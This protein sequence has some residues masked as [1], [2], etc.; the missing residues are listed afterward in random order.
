MKT[1]IKLLGPVILLG[2]LGAPMIGCED[3]DLTAPADGTIV[4]TANPAT[5]T[6]DPNAADP[7]RDPETG[8]LMAQSTI[9]ARV[10]D[11][12]GLPQ[13]NV[14]VIFST[15]AGRLDSAGAPGAPVQSIK[16]NANGVAQDVLTVRENDPADIT[17]TAQSSSIS[18]DVAVT[19][20]VSGLN[21]PPRASINPV[22]FAGGLAGEPVVFDGS[23]SVDPDGT[24]TMYRWTINSGNPDPGKPATEVVEEPNAFGLE[25]LY[26]FPQ[27]LLVTLEVTDD[28][29]AAAL[30][31]A[32]MPVP[33]DDFDVINYEISCNN[34]APTA[35]IAGPETIDLIVPAGQTQLILFDGTLSRDDETAID[36]WVW[37]CGNEFAPEPQN[38]LGSVVGCRYRGQST[39]RTYTATLDVVDRGTGRIDPATGT[40]EC[41]K[42]SEDSDRVTVNVSPPQ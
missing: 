7:P 15:T 27:T 14:A 34:R 26:D 39:A 4:L 24:I 21:E 22:P 25:R 28:P 18:E 35:I 5:L 40:W 37:S 32:G 30:L 36:R 9:V 20:I 13:E 29:D 42:S 1:G 16:T 10:F 2:L 41:Q 23:S 3:T 38:P 33:Y 11:G 8:Q 6:I 31:A 19:K 17:V 12:S